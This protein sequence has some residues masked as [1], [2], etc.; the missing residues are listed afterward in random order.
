MYSNSRVFSLSNRSVSQTAAAAI[1]LSPVA[2]A[3]PVR[4]SPRHRSATTVVPRLA[5]VSRLVRHSGPQEDAMLESFSRYVSTPHGAPARSPRHNAA[6][7]DARPTSRSP[8]LRIES[9]NRSCSGDN[10][11]ACEKWTL[12]ATA[13]FPCFLL[14]IPCSRAENSLFS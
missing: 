7:V 13:K 9:E 5:I 8:H 3:V 14:D 2:N 11:Q 6:G 10:E 4:A 1:P 12:T